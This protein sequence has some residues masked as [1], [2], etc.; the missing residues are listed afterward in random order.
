MQIT[1]VS[2]YQFS[3]FTK[4]FWALSQMGLAPRKLLCT[5]GLSFLKL[6]G[7]GADNGFGIKP[8][9][10][11]YGILAIW[12]NRAAAEQALA[13]NPTFLAYTK[14]STKQQTVFLVNTMAHG[15]WDGC[16]PFQSGK[17]FDP[18]APVAV[19][20]RATIKRRYLWRFWR[21]VPAVSRDVHDK[22]G[23]EYAIGIGELPLVQQATF[24]LWRSG[25]EM[26]DFAYRSEHHKQVIAQTRAFA[27]YKEELFARF[28]VLSN[29]F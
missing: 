9:W 28:E 6:M 11:T 18:T 7:S 26:M 27:W 8:N 4:K 17:A 1:T 3:G 22:P 20:T 21:Q 19:L 24:S 23:L 5:P 15:L 25:K 14:K 10:G 13:T 12:E 29:R 16:M 2:I